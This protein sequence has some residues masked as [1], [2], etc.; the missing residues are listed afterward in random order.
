MRMFDSSL[1]EVESELR[2]ISNK[3]LYSP[4]NGFYRSGLSVPIVRKRLKQ[5]YSFSS[6]NGLDQLKIWDF[7]WKKSTMYEAM[8][9]SLYFFQGRGLTKQEF[10]KIKTWVHRCSCWEHSDDLS[11]IYAQVVE[12]NPDWIVPHLERWNKSPSPWKRRQSV[13]SLLEYASKRKKALPF[14]KLI[15]FI[16]GLLDDEEYYVQKGVGW[17]LREIYNVYPRETLKYFDRNLRKISSIAYSAATEKLDKQTK[18]EFN[19]LRKAR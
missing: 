10:V 7:V 15:K 4:E 9:Q 1:K 14:K 16:D 2:K 11:K 6:L 3:R 5:G 18:S 12:D 19:R 8:S 17:T 13:V